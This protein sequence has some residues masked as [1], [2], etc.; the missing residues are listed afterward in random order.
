MGHL[1]QARHRHGCLEHSRRVSGYAS[2]TPC[3][4]M[5]CSSPNLHAGMT[6]RAVAWKANIIV[7]GTKDSELFLIDAQDQSHPR[8]L[9]AVSSITLWPI[10][11]L[12]TSDGP[13]AHAGR[14][15]GVVCS[16][17][18]SKVR[19]GRGRSDVTDLERHH[20]HLREPARP[21]LCA[22]VLPIPPRRAAAGSGRRQWQAIHHEFG[23][24]GGRSPPQC[25]PTSYGLT[26][27]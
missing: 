22:T 20:A 7:C 17:H 16:S 9:T 26:V 21:R 10:S 6:I 11:G 3:L 14:A 25:L 4:A 18:R 23:R 5:R 12:T 8:V 24:P 15:L 27:L 19:H 13:G 1:L 2:S